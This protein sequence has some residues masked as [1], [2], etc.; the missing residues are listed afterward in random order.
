MFRWGL[1]A[2][3]ITVMSFVVGL[4]WGV[5]GVAISYAVSAV[6]IAYPVFL[7]PA[8]LI[9]LPLFD[10][11]RA[12]QPIA[13]ATACMFL[14]VALAQWL[15]RSMSPMTILAVCVPVGIL[16][17]AILIKTFAP[18]LLHEVVTICRTLHTP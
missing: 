7:I 5:K 1:F 8:R 17:Y 11:W 16:A 4:P 10:L 18:G 2:S 15:A 3:P 13:L 12:V 6:L 14:A 9:D